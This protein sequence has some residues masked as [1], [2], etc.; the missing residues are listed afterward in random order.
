MT[1][2]KRSLAFVIFVFAS[3]TLSTAFLSTGAA[4]SITPGKTLSY[5]SDA[6][7]EGT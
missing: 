6:F 2:P 3:N 4:A 1:I 7:T 5:I